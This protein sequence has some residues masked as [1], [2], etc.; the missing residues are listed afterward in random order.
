MRKNL[1]FKT[2]ILSSGLALAM[3]G[4][5][6][7]GSSGDSQAPKPGVSKKASK[8][9]LRGFEETTL[10]NGL[11]VLYVPDENL[12]Y[13]SYSLLVKTGAAGD[14]VGQEGLGAFVAEMLDKGTSKRSATQIARDIGF[15][16]ADF[17]SS[18]GYDYSMISA[19]AIS[20]QAETLLKNVVEIAT[21]PSFSDAEIDRVRKQMLAG[22][23][24]RVDNPDAFAD[25]AFTEYLYGA[26]PYGKAVTGSKKSIMAVSKR[27]LIRQYLRFYRPNNAIL[28]VVGKY[29]P[30]LRAKVE[31]SFGAWE[32]RETP[33][34]EM[35]TIA[36][37]TG[38]QIRL[39]D[40]PG[41]VQAQVR[42]GHLGIARNSPDFMA[43]RLANTVLGGAFSSRLNDRLR[44]DLGL[45]YSVGSSYD[46]RKDRGPFTIE[47]FTKNASVGQVVSETLKVLEEYR[48]NG[49]TTEDI[50]RAKGYLKG[51]FPASIES[52]EKLAFNLMVLRLY[53]ISDDYL[54]DYI[55]NVDDLSKS[56]VNEAI[57]KYLHPDKLKVL[58]YTSA[59]EVTPQLKTIAPNEGALEVK[60][61]SEL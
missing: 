53:G 43:L 40:K 2:A 13:I 17:S 61:A 27:N 5:A 31:A 39:L 45:T 25:L 56:E 6:S 35:P 21:D 33:A 14:P 34:V 48:T 47:T 3:A 51:I 10:P 12:P 49:V 57:K 1:A 28:A 59:P 54:S 30:E 23:Q 9:L 44:K 22:I 46:A 36:E 37:P 4:C 60:K 29:T 20:T 16:G 50:N 26:H 55:S 41:L 24:R 52:A 15:M 19:S 11:R 8:G 42:F 32:N 38:L 18:A 7:G 58:V